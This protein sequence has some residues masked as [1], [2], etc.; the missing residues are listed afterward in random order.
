M[1]PAV[2]WTGG[3]VG[4]DRYSIGGGQ[5]VG[6]LLQRGRIR[7]W[8]C[9]NVYRAVGRHFDV[10]IQLRFLETRIVTHIDRTLARAH[11]DGVSPRKSAGHAV[12]GGRLVIPLDEI[13]DHFTL[14]VGRVD[15]V[16][17]WTAFRLGH[18][19]GGADDKNRRAVEI[20]VVD[21]HGR[22]QQTDEVVHD[23]DH[24][25]A[26]GTGIAVG[27]LDGDFFVLAEQHRR[28]VLA[29]VDQRVVQPAI[30]R[31]RVERDIFEVVTLDHV[32]DD[33]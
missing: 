27:D 15:P 17:K 10:M 16:N 28:I 9:G 6:R 30:A 24:R 29:V 33:V 5:S 26:F 21:A 25:L 13:A 18:G 1:L 4:D 31:A 8:S 11:H 19:T 2:R 12:D 14:S 22:V 32:D 20:G 7:G 23:G 3:E